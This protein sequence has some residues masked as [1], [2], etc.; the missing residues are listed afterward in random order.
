MEGVQLLR[1]SLGREAVDVVILSAGYGV[2]PEDKTI[3]PYEVTFNTM[4]GY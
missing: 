4:K 3:V 2:I 1:Q